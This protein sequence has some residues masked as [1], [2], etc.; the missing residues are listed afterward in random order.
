MK[1]IE[2]YLQEA[3]IIIVGEYPKTDDRYI[4]AIET[5]KIFGFDLGENG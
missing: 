2:Q 1:S 5:G 3:L 4:F